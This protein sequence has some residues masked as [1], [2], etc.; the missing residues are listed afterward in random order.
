MVTTVGRIRP[1]IPSTLNAFC[2]A[3]YDKGT[4][5][6][7][8]GFPDYEKNTLKPEFYRDSFYDSR[9]LLNKNHNYS[10]GYF[11]YFFGHTEVDTSR[12]GYYKRPYNYYQNTQDFSIISTY[13]P[14]VDNQCDR[15]FVLDTGVLRY[16]A[17][18]LYTVQNPAIIVFDL[19]FNGCYD[20]NFPVIRRVEI[21][22]HLWTIAF[23][24]TFIS[25][26]YKPKGSC[27]DVLLYI[28]N[29]FDSNIIVYDYK[30]GDFW[31]ISDPS[32]K[33]ITAEATLTY[34]GVSYVIPIGIINVALGWPDKHGYRNA[35]YAP[36]SSLAEYVVSTKVLQDSKGVF[37]KYDSSEFTF[38]GY[39]GCNS[40]NYKQVFDP[41]TGVIFFGEMQSN[42]IR[43]WNTQLP[44]NPD[45]IGIVYESDESVFF[46]DMSLDSEG[47][48]WF[49]TNQ[50]PIIFNSGDLLDISEVNSRVFRVKPSEA[51]KGTVCD[52]SYQYY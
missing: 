36:G 41:N 13:F 11:N 44:L 42:R 14:N 4:S 35:Y 12:K 39:R 20:R 52:I 6:Y 43:C 16:S 45:T 29:I 25:F 40:E 27:D 1:G 50:L 23:G 24:F 49:F 21:P 37:N 3:D 17:T 51:I 31:S 15:L 8:W 33:P 5:P 48:L 22:S 46:G 38:I 26:D 9:N 30:K 19:P 10:A 34:R 32:M 2:V 47:N 28:T 18:E 7:I